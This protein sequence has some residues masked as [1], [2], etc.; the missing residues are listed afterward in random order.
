MDQAAPQHQEEGGSRRITDGNLMFLM[1]SLS[2]QIDRIQYVDRNDSATFADSYGRRYG[3]ALMGLTPTRPGEPTTPYVSVTFEM[4]YRSARTTDQRSVTEIDPSISLGVGVLQC[5]G[6]HVACYVGPRIGIG[7]V[8]IS[9]QRLTGD[10]SYQY[11][12]NGTTLRLGADFGVVADFDGV[13]LIWQVGYEVKLTEARFG[14]ATQ[15]FGTADYIT[16]G[17]VFSFGIGGRF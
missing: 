6:E 5:L 13:D 12:T 3:L 8:F 9:D 16:R 4:D 17:L 11:S 1:G 14:D 15:N 10:T 2:P 7:Y